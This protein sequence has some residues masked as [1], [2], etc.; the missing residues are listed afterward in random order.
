MWIIGIRYGYIITSEEYVY[1]KNVLLEG[2][3][4]VTIKD[5]NGNVTIYPVHQIHKLTG[6]YL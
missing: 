2:G 5:K 6:R 3:N 4:A 1:V